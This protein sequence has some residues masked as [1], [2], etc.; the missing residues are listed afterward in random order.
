MGTRCGQILVQLLRLDNQL[1]ILSIHT[2]AKGLDN[3][4]NQDFSNLCSEERGPAGQAA[5][6]PVQEGKD[7]L[8]IKL[9]SNPGRETHV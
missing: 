6:L 9:W 4:I 2:R 1:S 3:D 7:Q 5:E 8:E